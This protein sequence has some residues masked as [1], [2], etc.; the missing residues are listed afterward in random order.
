MYRKFIM[1]FS[2]L[3]AFLLPFS[4][5][6]TYAAQSGSTTSVAWTQLETKT[7]TD[8]NK[9]WSIKFSL[10]LDPTSVDK[11]NVYVKDSNGNLVETKLSVANDIVKI[12]P[13]T[14]YQVGKKYS[15]YIGPDIQSTKGKILKTNVKFDFTVESGTIGE[16]G[17]PVIYPSNTVPVDYSED[18][19]RL[20]VPLPVTTSELANYDES[21][22][23]SSVKL[24][25]LNDATQQWE[26]V[27]SLF[28]SG[29]LQK[30]SDEI[31]GD[32]YY[33][34]NLLDKI[35]TSSPENLKLKVVAQL[36]NGNNLTATTSLVTVQTSNG[37]NVEKI[38]D[39]SNDIE[40]QV[41]AYSTSNSNVSVA[42]VNKVVQKDLASQE[43]VVSVKKESDGLLEV[44]YDT[45]LKSLIQIVG[46]E[47]PEAGVRSI[48]TGSDSREVSILNESSTLGQA[49]EER[50][51]SAGV[52]LEQQTRG[53]KV[54]IVLPTQPTSTVE[55]SSIGSS[56]DI[57]SRNVLL[58]APFS[59]EFHPWNEEDKLYSIFNKSPLGFNI[60]KREGQEADIESLKNLTNYGFVLLSTHGSGGKWVLTGEQATDYSKY[61]VEQILG[62]LMVT[63]HIVVTS[64]NG[65]K[66]KA[67]V[68]AVN[69][70][71]FDHNL[72]GTFDKTIFIN[73]S[74][75]STMTD[76][77]WNVFKEK[78]AGAYYGFSKSVTSKFAYQKSIEIVDNLV[79]KGKTTGTSYTKN[80][81]DPYSS[82]KATIELKGNTSLAFASNSEEN[83]NLLNGDFEQMNATTQGPTNWQVSGD[84]RVIS[85]LGSNKFVSPTNGK[86]MAIISTGLGYTTELGQIQQTFYL[87]PNSTTLSFDWN[88]LSE[89]FLEYIDS[90][91]DDPFYVTLSTK[92]GM[93]EQV[94]S[95]TIDDLASQFGAD[96]ID[97]GQLISVSPTIQFDRGDVWMT[98]WQK[99]QYKIPD[100]FKGK[101]VTL[102]FTTQDAQDTIYDTAVLIDNI[103]IQ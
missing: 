47:D 92:D 21:T 102:K 71:W 31:S 80:E 89:E 65:V 59:N 27:G 78:N 26:E 51:K 7:T 25:S 34:I 76:N 10:N 50:S 101:I 60:D 84:G 35:D 44:T 72:K 99:H 8:V 75:E 96:E 1:V 43:N 4:S 2:F 77:L 3:L 18:G 81:S 38:I 13:T 48:S 73:S 29:N 56:N 33:S 66:V 41:N 70:K 95:L 61:E 20:V 74:C 57:T 97:G 94:L 32:G 24:Y 58:W 100:E 87:S 63:Q 16:M 11:N 54:D 45:G 64:H 19:F 55:S 86:N 14:S 15:V 22:N 36:K 90:G 39:V 49:R 79:N 9:E 67:P 88:Y 23:Q 69:Q 93:E 40:Q 62:E 28:D 46:E 5:S 30:D 68:Y 17:T 6:F 53:D 85:G 98:N 42:D 83:T 82:D 37:E 12:I 103:K 52:P 91:F